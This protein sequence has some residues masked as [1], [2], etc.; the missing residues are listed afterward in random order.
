MTRE[1]VRF[2]YWVLLIGSLSVFIAFMVIWLWPS[3]PFRFLQFQTAVAADDHV[4]VNRR[5]MNRAYAFKADFD[6]IHQR[7]TE[8]LTL[9]GFKLIADD[10]HFRF[11]AVQYER[12]TES[13]GRLRRDQVILFKDMQYKMHQHGESYSVV[14]QDDVGWV[15]FSVTLEEPIGKIDSM[16]MKVREWLGL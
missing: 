15:S 12:S 8:E 2:R 10:H 9:L 1:T 5:Q 4:N 11:R 3:P 13:N 7:V 16:M 6:Q 14:G